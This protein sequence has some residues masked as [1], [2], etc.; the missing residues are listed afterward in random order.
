MINPELRLLICT[1][2]SALTQPALEY[3]VWLSGL[4][5]M[6]ATLLGIIERPEDRTSTEKLIGLAEKQLSDRGLAFQT[7]FEYG[8]SRRVITEI[9]RA[10]VYISVVGPL[11]R[12]ALKRLVQGRSFRRLMANVVT[13]IVY[14]P[15]VRLPLRK[16]ILCMGGL[17]PVSG[18]EHL[19]VLLCQ[20][21]QAEI[22][23]LH[24]VEPVTLDY[25]TAREVRLNWE[26]ILDTDT[27]Q[28][29]NLKMALHEI[30]DA[31]VKAEFK[32]RHGNPVHEIMD[33]ICNAPYDLVAMGSTYR[34]HN[35]RRLYLPNVTAEV[36]ES[37]D[38][39]VIT[40]RKSHYPDVVD[41]HLQER[42]K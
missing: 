22:T 37:I 31:G 35:L 8:N 11:G 38:R 3:G 17:E 26:S 21:V 30:K 19:A 29:R 24:V 20:K 15:R 34:A 42:E 32:V 4:L 9:T 18:A 33:E 40:M 23:L 12:P 36:A 2:G 16:A 27:P 14:V 6:P 39:P 25:P 1:N 41:P 13:P 5:N 10:G 7:R 28:G